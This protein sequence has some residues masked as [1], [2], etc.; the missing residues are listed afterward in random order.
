LTYKPIVDK[1]VQ[2]S[3]FLKDFVH[4]FL[5]KVCVS[6]DVSLLSH[7]EVLCTECI[8]HLPLTDFHQDEQNETAQ[9]LWGKLDFKQA[10][11]MLYL[12]KSS[13]VAK[14]VHK[15]KYGNEPDIGIFLGQYYAKILQPT[16]IFEQL[17]MIVP[18]PIH[19]S[20]LRKRGYNQAGQFA[21]G[22]S[23]MSGVPW[24][25]DILIRTKATESQIQKNR[26]ERYDNVEGVFALRRPSLI[27]EKH[28]LLVD[29][30]LT[31]GATIC[32]AGNQLV[33]A[34]ASVS[35]ATI[36]RA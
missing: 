4:I 3:F 13:R 6:C 21:K 2:I 19:S 31:T 28:V 9:Q 5:P 34:G 30:V 22:L 15:L 18:V 16:G 8:Y 29:D 26:I 11:S 12:A 35:V 32:V 25:E 27:K 14:L 10:V 36:A 7:E 33:Q 23:K 20:K 17:D 1:V 24:N